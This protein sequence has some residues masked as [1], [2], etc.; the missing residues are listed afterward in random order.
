MK[1]A[2]QNCCLKLKKINETLTFNTKLSTFLRNKH[3]NQYFPNLY[4]SYILMM[5]LLFWKIA[6]H[7][8]LNAFNTQQ[9]NIKICS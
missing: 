5:L 4:F 1:Y 7:I 8:F 3:E 9:K 6:M 2:H